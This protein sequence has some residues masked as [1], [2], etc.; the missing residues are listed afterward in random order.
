MDL[1]LFMISLGLI[2]CRIICIICTCMIYGV[3]SSHREAGTGTLPSSFSSLTPSFLPSFDDNY[4]KVLV[5]SSFSLSGNKK[6]KYSFSNFVKWKPHKN[7]LKSVTG[8]FREGLCTSVGWLWRKR[9]LHL[10]WGQIWCHFRGFQPRTIIPHGN[11]SCLMRWGFQ[12]RNGESKP[13]KWLPFLFQRKIKQ[14]HKVLVRCVWRNR[15]FWPACQR[16][17][18]FREKLGLHLHG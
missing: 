14:P 8:A 1:E 5:I 3:C 16:R 10:H 6:G 11:A 9:G 4:C 15:W 2:L 17:S 13:G 12:S 18:S 7:V